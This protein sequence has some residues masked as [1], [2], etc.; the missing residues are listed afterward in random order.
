VAIARGWLAESGFAKEAEGNAVQVVAAMNEHYPDG[1][2]FFLSINDLHKEDFR[3]NYMKS[4]EYTPERQALHNGIRA[5][6]LS[7]A[8]LPPPGEQPMALFLAGGSGAGK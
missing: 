8:H 3:R 4:G 6:Y 1:W 7:T 2:E 5:A